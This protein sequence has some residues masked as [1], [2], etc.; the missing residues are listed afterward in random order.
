M[1]NEN[2]QD[3]A[4]HDNQNQQNPLPA[5]YPL[6]DR[7]NGFN[8][9]L[10]DDSDDD[11]TPPATP[12]RAQEAL[13]E[14]INHLTP[15]P[16]I[17][18]SHNSNQSYHSDEELFQRNNYQWSDIS[19][20]STLSSEPAPYY[21]HASQE[22]YSESDNRS[23]LSST[24]EYGITK[25]SLHASDSSHDLSEN[26]N[27]LFR[28]STF[29]YEPDLRPDTVRENISLNDS[30]PC[31]QPSLYRYGEYLASKQ[32]SNY[33]YNQSDDQDA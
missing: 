28:S 32:E 24:Y 20:Q 5:Y 9:N 22:S 19:S 14:D 33:E 4:D 25:Y 18:S 23:Q 7:I 16:S 29:V 13:L 27:T 17:H 10:Q 26:Q 15:S 8:A 3:H 30:I 11:G 21:Y 2:S 6:Q 31:S 1:G 12:I